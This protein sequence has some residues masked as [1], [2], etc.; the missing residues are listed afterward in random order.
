MNLN[1]IKFTPEEADSLKAAVEDRLACGIHFENAPI[2]R[3]SDEAGAS[4]VASPGGK[5]TGVPRM[6]MEPSAPLD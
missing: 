1:A 4:E 5:P 2:D 6:V 3:C